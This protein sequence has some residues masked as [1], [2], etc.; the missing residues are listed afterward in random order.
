MT[1]SYLNPTGHPDPL[2]Y[3]I[4]A[5]VLLLAAE[6]LWARRVHVEPATDV[7]VDPQ[8]GSIR[9]FSWRDSV[10]SISMG[11]GSLVVT[12]ITKA[13]EVAL[14]L[15]ANAHSLFTI[16]PTWW[17]WLLLVFLD[18]LCYWVYHATSHKSRFFWA[19]HVNHHSS[20][21]YNLSTA[22]RQSWTKQVITP[23][24]W[25]PLAILGFPAWMIVMQQAF[26]LIYQYWIHTEMVRSIGP[27]EWLF[28]SPSHHRVHHASNQRYL[29]KN[30]AGTFMFWDRLF[31][32]FEP[33]G[34]PVVYGL[35]KN[36]HGY[37]LVHIAF[38]EYADIL[39]D[40]R[41]ARSLREA[42]MFTFGPPGWAP[43]DAF[44]TASGEPAHGGTGHT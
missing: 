29:D 31:G 5:F 1:P 25:L 18:D 39:R 35:T 9:G 37:N 15:F 19:S 13:P 17:S 14:Y 26:S 38:H 32:T 2:L 21:H 11:L 33:E 43:A 10:A 44:V 23:W 16:P 40:V 24:F 3:A 30:H 7:P 42:W 4:P 41:S 20:E 8:H 22:L 36:I 28:N 12:A 34:E 6:V 27:L